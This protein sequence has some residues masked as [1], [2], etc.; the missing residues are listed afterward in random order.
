MA[1]AHQSDA[2]PLEPGARSTSG[3]RSDACGWLVV[4]GGRFAS[5]SFAVW[6]GKMVETLRAYVFAHESH[7]D[8]GCPPTSAAPPSSRA[9]PPSMVNQLGLP[10]DCHRWTAMAHGSQRSPAVPYGSV[11]RREQVGDGAAAGC[12][13]ARARAGCGMPEQV[14][15]VRVSSQSRITVQEEVGFL[16]RS[17]EFLSVLLGWVSRVAPN[18]Q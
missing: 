7:V 5:I 3:V 8:H 6:R 4:G 18:L 9:V 11:G 16:G 1:L 10:Q 13:S 14:F 15:F 2:V 17:R 12:G